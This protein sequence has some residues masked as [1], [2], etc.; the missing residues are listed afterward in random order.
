MD[1]TP[2]S[3]PETQSTK[4]E[5]QPGAGTQFQTTDR[6]RPENEFQPTDV[7]GSSQPTKTELTPGGGAQD[8][9]G[10]TK[11]VLEPASGH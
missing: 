8:S 11:E 4:E 5:L 2:G 3:G 10:T 7:P 6:E 9:E 1:L